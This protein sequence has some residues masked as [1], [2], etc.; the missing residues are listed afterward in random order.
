MERKETME[1]YRVLEDKNGN[2]KVKLF[3][4][5]KHVDYMGPDSGVYKGKIDGTTYLAYVNGNAQSAKPGHS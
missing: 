2:K 4:D 1:I 3:M 5:F